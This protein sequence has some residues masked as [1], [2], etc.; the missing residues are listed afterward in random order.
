MRPAAGHRSIWLFPC[1]NAVV[2]AFCCSD[3]HPR[4]TSPS[5]KD[6]E[7]GPSDDRVEP[8]KCSPCDV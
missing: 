2:V 7:T 1:S 3:G 5:G 8:L 6:C 4:R